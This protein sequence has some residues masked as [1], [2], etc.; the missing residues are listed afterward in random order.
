MLDGDID[1]ENVG[2]LSRALDDNPAARRMNTVLDAIAQR[3]TLTREQVGDI[4]IASRQELEDTYGIRTKVRE[5][6]EALYT[7][8]QGLSDLN[9]SDEFAAYT[10][11]R[12]S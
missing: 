3:C 7:S 12:G 9:C 2:G 1:P 4:A 10:V 5:V 11:S 8:T 6:L